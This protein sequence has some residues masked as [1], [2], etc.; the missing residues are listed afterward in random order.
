[1]TVRSIEIRKSSGT[2]LGTVPVG[3]AG[4]TQDY[5]FKNI[6]GLGPV[7]AQLSMYNFSSYDGSV[8]HNA[9]LT[10][11]NIVLTL[12]YSP[13]YTNGKDIGA[14]RKQAYLWFKPKSSV[15]LYINDS[16]RERVYVTGIVEK[17]TPNIFSKDPE[18]QISLI[19]EN[20]YFLRPSMISMNGVANTAYDLSTYG[21]APTGFAMVITPK[22]NF[23]VFTIRGGTQD[24]MLFRYPFAANDTVR[25]GVN[26][27]NKY[28]TVTRAGVTTPIIDR[29]EGTTLQ[30][31]L[32]DTVT[33][34]GMFTNEGAAADFLLQFRPAWIGV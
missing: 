8:L 33:N 30:M 3:K 24:Y 5:F 14:L 22:V 17:V 7:D 4:A 13:N 6:D 31:F 10:Q 15:T 34:F 19:C 26:P 20:P 32:D 27:G 9:R 23:S 16:D 21:D 12:G 18:I 29:M 28:A 1:M 11:R 2:V 25:I